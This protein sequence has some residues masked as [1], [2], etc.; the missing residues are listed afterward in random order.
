[1]RI[2]K[3]EV[4]MAIIAIN[5]GHYLG[6]E[7][8]D[9]GACNED[10]GLTEAGINV[11]VAHKIERILQSRGHQVVYIHKGELYEITDASNAADAD[12]FV[13]IHCNSVQFMAWKLSIMRQVLM[14]VGSQH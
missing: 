5:A 7:N 6:Q 2:S 3:G 10:L 9:S 14:A 13:S 1:M 12:V 4:S 11:V 8:Y